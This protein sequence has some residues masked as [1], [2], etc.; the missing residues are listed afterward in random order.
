MKKGKEKYLKALKELGL[1]ERIFRAFE[2]QDR[3]VFVDPPFAERTWELGV[4]PAGKGEVMDDPLTLAKMINI[5]APTR[6]ERVLEIGTGSGYST[7]ILGELS[8]EVV[9]LEQH[10]ELGRMAKERLIRE[11]VYNVKILAGDASDIIGDEKGF[12][13]CLITGSVSRRPFAIL[14]TLKTGGRAVFPMGPPHQQQIVLYRHLDEFVL[15]TNRYIS[16]H[17]LCQFPSLRGEY[18]WIDQD[19]DLFGFMDDEER[20]EESTVNGEETSATS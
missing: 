5:L 11:G 4:L 8:R 1:A 2:S 20:E 7:A 10:E 12:D 6:K 9:S 14:T 13:A 3:S 15:D 16:F 19:D 17:D 18:G